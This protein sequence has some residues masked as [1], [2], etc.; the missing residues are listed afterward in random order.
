MRRPAFLAGCRFL[1]PR[2]VLDPSGST[3]PDRGEVEEGFPIVR[4]ARQLGPGQTLLSVGVA[5]RGP[6]KNARSP[7]FDVKGHYSAAF[8]GLFRCPP[9]WARLLP[10]TDRGMDARWSRRGGQI[11]S[12]SLAQKDRG[13]FWKTFALPWK[14]TGGV[15]F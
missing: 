13:L 8:W 10:E 12:I 1:D 3:D 9:C 15:H 14:M 6:G 11:R 2:G 5:C 4:I 7:N